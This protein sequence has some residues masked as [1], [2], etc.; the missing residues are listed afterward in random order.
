MDCFTF[1]NEFDLLEARLREVGNVVDF[2]VLCEATK[3]HVGKPK[4][5]LFEAHASRYA[6]WLPKIV[7]VVD[8]DMPEHAA[9]A[10]TREHHQ[11]EALRFGAFDGVESIPRR[12]SRKITYQA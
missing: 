2:F 6:E 3:T 11:R 7:H 4:E 8:D 9:D 5:L 1:Y 12:A 10:W